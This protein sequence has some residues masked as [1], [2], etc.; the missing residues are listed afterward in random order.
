MNRGVGMLEG[1]KSQRHVA[2]Q[3]GV[4]QSVVARIWSR[5]QMHV[6]VIPR[7]KGGRRRATT[8]AQHRFIVVLDRHHRFMNAMALQND[9]HN[10]SGVR[11]ST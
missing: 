10:A 7:Y 11:V 5:Y 4:P 3:P 8:Q 6:Y 1:G 2:R 9:L